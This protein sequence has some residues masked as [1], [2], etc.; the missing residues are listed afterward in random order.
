MF[1][2]KR[3]GN[4]NNDMFFQT[5]HWKNTTFS[6]YCILPEQT[7][8]LYSVPLKTAVIW[9]K[10]CRHGNLYFLPRSDILCWILFL[11]RQ[12]QAHLKGPSTFASVLPVPIFCLF[13][14]VNYHTI[15]FFIENSHMKW[16]FCYCDTWS[17]CLFL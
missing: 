5:N 15:G 4:L 16:K 14:K 7:D 3:P 12:I 8:Y 10:Y 11:L 1:N 17:R 9:L 2:Q 6:Y 13:L